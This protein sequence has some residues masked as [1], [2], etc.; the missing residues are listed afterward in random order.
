MNAV[1]DPRKSIIDVLAA[2]FAAHGFVLKRGRAFEKAGADGLLY[3]YNVNL[4]KRKGWHA[5]HLTLEVLDRPLM[6]EVNRILA[7]VLDDDSYDY[8]DSWSR[9]IVE[10]TKAGRIRN[11]VVAGLTDWRE[12]RDAGESLQDFNG[13]FSLWLYAFDDIG[14]RA[15]WREQLSTSIELSVRW[16]ERAG[17]LEWIIENTEL[18]ALYLLKRQG[19]D[20]ELAEKYAYLQQ[21]V[22]DRKELA[23]FCKCLNL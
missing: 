21:R 10:S 7:R 11:Q 1:Q 16:F 5:L 9:K 17:T 8:P 22:A 15:D 4:S 23:L 3:R 12:L 6:A 13:R 2:G 20:P 18:P 14:E 19:R